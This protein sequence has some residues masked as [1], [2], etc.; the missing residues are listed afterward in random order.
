MIAN[1]LHITT[2]T[3]TL[4]GLSP[5]PAVEGGN[6]CRAHARMARSAVNVTEPACAIHGR[7]RCGCGEY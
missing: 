4:S 3:T 2:D 6:L 5:N 7:Q 1:Q